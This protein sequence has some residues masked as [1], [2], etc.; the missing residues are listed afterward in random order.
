MLECVSDAFYAVDRD[1][2]VVMFNGPAEAFFGI[3]RERALGSDLWEIYGKG[4][5]TEFGR[6]IRR[7]MN[8]RAPGRLTAPSALRRGRTVEVRISPLGDEGVGVA[9]DDI[10]ERHEAERAL[11]QSQERLNLAVS[12]HQIGIFDWHLPTGEIVWSAEEAQIFGM[13]PEPGRGGRADWLENLE[14]RDASELE[15]GMQA[16]IA[17]GREVMALRFRV[18]RGDGDV[19]YVEGGARLLYAPDGSPLRMVGAN[20]DVTE[21]RIAEAH[22]R[23][24]INE[25]NHRVKN[26]LAIVQA[27]AW[28]SLRDGVPRS[29]REAFEGRLSALA[30]A[31]DVLTR[32]NW[33]SASIARII[34][35]ATAPHHSGQLCA[36]GPD[37]ELPPKTAVA[38]GLAMHELATNAVK[39]GALSQPGGTVTVRWS[40]EGRRLALSWTETGGPEPAPVPARRGFGMRMLEQGLAEELCGTVTLDFRPQGLVCEVDAMLPA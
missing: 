32:Q 40:A 2:T 17:A 24:L 26:T 19:R 15:A 6:L 14:A 13:A 34:D 20:M 3:T 9:I 38:L 22:Q 11:R 16:A 18:R 31:H 7:A 27:I 10:T 33:E 8:E 4:P 1:W 12:A 37:V 35:Q 39:H 36:A 28:Q 30:A 5:D 21:R 23:L 29:V 25:L